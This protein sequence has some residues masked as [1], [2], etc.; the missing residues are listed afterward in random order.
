MAKIHLNDMRF[1]AYH[2]CFEEEKVVGTHFS[3]DC[4]LEVP[5]SEAAK[6]D[7]L[8]QTLNYQDVYLLIA[9]EMKQASS[10]LE[11]LAWRILTQLH[12]QY[13]MVETATVAIHKLN[14]PL[15]GQTGSVCV[16]LSTK[17]VMINK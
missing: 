5:C 7:D 15:G 8:T 9:D 16:E 14:P 13:P 10:I 17:D 6:Q 4:S 1:Y 12:G 11:H 3:V 2:G